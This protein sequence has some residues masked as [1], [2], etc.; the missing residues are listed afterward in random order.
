MSLKI[1]NAQG[2]EVRTIITGTHSIGS[3][4]TLFDG[5][6]LNSGVYF[7]I[8]QESNFVAMK[9]ARLLC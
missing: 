7:Y 9:K 5:E 4:A 1:D 3:E 8:L 6:N 2:Q